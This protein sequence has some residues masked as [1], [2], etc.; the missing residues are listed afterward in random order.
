MPKPVPAAPA[1]GR[2]GSE[3]E[4]IDLRPPYDFVDGRTLDAGSHIVAVAG[5][6]AA[7]PD[8]VCIARDGTLWDC[9]ELATKAFESAV[10]NKT[11]R[12]KLDG[13]AAARRLSGVCTAVMILQANL[14]SQV[15]SVPSVSISSGLS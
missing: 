1:P 2:V 12:C 8:E 7:G 13:Q 14:S 9:S 4:W 6:T 15:G 5:V 11:L 3:D 10:R